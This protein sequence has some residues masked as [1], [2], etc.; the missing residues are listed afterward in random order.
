MIMRQGV[1]RLRATAGGWLLVFEHDA[2][3]PWARIKHDGKAFV[4]DEG[5]A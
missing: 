2:T 3:T 5:N 4:V 1:D